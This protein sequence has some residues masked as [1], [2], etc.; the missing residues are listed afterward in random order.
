MAIF[1]LV[2][3][4]FHASWCWREVAPRLEARGHRVL[5]LD[6][7][8]HGTDPTPLERVCFQD[9]VDAIRRVVG[10]LDERSILV[11]H[12]MGTPIAGA[13]EADPDALAALV[14]VAGLL[15]RPPQGVYTNLRDTEGLAVSCRRG[16]A[17]GHLGRQAIH[18]DQ[19][20]VIVSAY[21]P[22]PDEVER[23]RATIERL[24]QSASA[25]A[26]ENGAFV[27]GAMLGAA[28][29]VVEVWEAYGA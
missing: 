16:R 6:L 14:F 25:S 3:G 19:L 29:Q 28:R 21:L 26:L 23:A 9:Y 8:G 11:G 17:L 27:D 13:A 15:P 2:H 22:T 24:Q 12:S 7:P 1:V 5:A 18:P 4:S 10:R 20:P